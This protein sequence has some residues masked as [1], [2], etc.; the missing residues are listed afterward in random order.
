MQS[1][2]RISFEQADWADKNFMN[3]EKSIAI[4]NAL[5]YT[6]VSYRIGFVSRR[7]GH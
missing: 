5:C 6:N 7:N 1:C 2:A 4:L 3:F